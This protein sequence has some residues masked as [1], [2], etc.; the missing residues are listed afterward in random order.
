MAVIWT[1]TPWTLPANEAIAIHPELDYG[2]YETDERLL[3]L[4][5]DLAEERLSKY[6][7][8]SLILEYAKEVS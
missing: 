3:I 7:F 2:I 8:K 5:I 6:K 1:T 4:S